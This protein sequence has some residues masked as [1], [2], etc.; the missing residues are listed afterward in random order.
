[1]RPTSVRWRIFGLACGTSF[2]LY[3][4]RYTWNLVGPELQ[5]DHGLSNTQAQI[6]FS[7]F[8]YTYATAQV[9][10]GILIDR[11]GPHRFLSIG[12]V[13]WSLALGGLALAPALWMLGGFRLLFGLGQAGCYPA[14]TKMT[15]SWFPASRRTVLQGWIATTAG[16]SG[17]ALA[18]IVLGSLLMGALG[19]SWQTSLLIL[20]ALG[21]AWG[22]A[23]AIGFRDTPADHPG[24]N[25]AERAL[26]D[27]G[28]KPSVN[29][30][31]E[32]FPW[33]RAIRSRSLAAF[34]AQQFLDAG[35]DVAFVSLMGAYFLRA[36]GFDFSKTG[37]LASLPLWGGA[38]GGIAGGWL[39]DRLIYRT[40]NRR[41]TRSGVGA[42]G[43]L[44]GCGM[45]AL[46]TKP[47]DG[48]MA[49]FV[50]MLAKFFSDWSQPTVWGTCTDLG[51]RFSAT[52][53][54]IINTAGTLGGVAMPV[55][56]GLVLDACTRWIVKD[57]TTIPFT[58]WNPLFLLLA[59]MYLGSGICW[60]L[61][62]CTQRLDLPEKPP[63]IAEI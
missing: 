46:V 17:G 1:M 61:I 26:I 9:P 2:L 55:V 10:S 51:G 25:G 8:Y 19:L 49:A 58:D 62:D 16:R 34:V 3:L 47:E 56:F 45:L 28:E 35:S 29:A 30:P 15:R 23:F 60:L 38:L 20:S 40:G 33:D 14:L 59:A 52:V 44:I 43:K 27:E 4:H 36:R 11:A 37:W 21:I 63:T 32:R 7:L 41:W 6:L 50:L 22:I 39:N 24:V 42:V 31:T 18:P 53:F 5:Q 13:A 48:V 12:I 57:D 54:S